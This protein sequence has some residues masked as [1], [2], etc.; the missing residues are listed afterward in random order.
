MEIPRSI[1]DNLTEQLNSLSESTQALVLEEIKRIEYEDI[2]EL[3]EKVAEIM[4]DYLSAAADQAAAYS[5]TTYDA[6]RYLAV[7]E[8]MGADVLPGYEDAATIGSVRAMVQDVVD[9]GNLDTFINKCLERCDYEIKK[10]AA[11]CSMKNASNDPLEP[12]WAR[13]PT[14]RETCDF[15]IMLASRS[16]VYHDEKRAGALDHWHAHCDCRVVQ[17]YKGMTVEGYNP[18]E[19]YNNW[20]SSKHYKYMQGRADRLTEA[21]FIRHIQKQEMKAGATKEEAIELTKDLA[22]KF[23]EKYGKDYTKVYQKT[24]VERNEKQKERRRQRD[25]ER[26]REI[27]ERKNNL[28]KKIIR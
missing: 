25:L 18:E 6:I 17:G 26:K 27:E 15:C 13:V 22:D 19:L 9:T 3:R 10:A 7:D 2:A 8:V 28:S 21:N 20:I 11:H 12:R 23:K 14:G 24:Q 4:V 16:F 1:L 5:A